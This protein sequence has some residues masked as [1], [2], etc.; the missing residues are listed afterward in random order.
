M[1][2]FGILFIAL[3]G[4]VVTTNAQ[5]TEVANTAATIIT[6]ISISKTSDLNFGNVAVSAVTAGTAVITTGGV[7]SGTAG[8]TIPAAGG[9]PT[10]AAF[11]INGQ[12]T[13]GFTISFDN[14]SITLTKAGGGTMTVD[15]FVSSLGA[16]SALVG[17][18]KPLTVG[19]T[20][21][22]AAGQ[23]AGLYENTGD[24]S[25]TVNYN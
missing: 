15:N 22:V 7:V 11:T 6:P 24:L 8:V 20:L 1:K 3:I 5:D 4:F 17:G 19:A 21:N 16:S 12:G 18:T 14:A 10:A 23:A 25:V 2:K 9:T 13:N